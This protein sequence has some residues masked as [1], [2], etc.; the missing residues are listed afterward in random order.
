MVRYV[1]NLSSLNETNKLEKIG[2]KIFAASHSQD[3]KIE[4]LS[5]NKIKVTYFAR[6][7]YKKVN[8]YKTILFEYDENT[9]YFENSQK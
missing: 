3:L 4:K 8:K 6:E 5:T 2:K 7:V 1:D 9:K